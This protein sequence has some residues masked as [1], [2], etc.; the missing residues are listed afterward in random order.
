MLVLIAS[1]AILYH[2]HCDGSLKAVP[3]HTNK[4]DMVMI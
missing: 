1:H 3:P 4:M 2:L